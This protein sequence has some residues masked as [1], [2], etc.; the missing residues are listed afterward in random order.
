MAP[1]D[2]DP[3]PSG[4]W[5]PRGARAPGHHA[6]VTADPQQDRTLSRAH[7]DTPSVPRSNGPA[8]A[9]PLLLT[10]GRGPFARGRP[11]PKSR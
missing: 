9:E 2:T 5:P 4:P 8:R 3:G 1:E 11:P 6:T 10:G 7:D